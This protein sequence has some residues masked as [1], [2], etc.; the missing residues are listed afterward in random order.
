MAWSPS[1][2]GSWLTLPLTHLLAP[3]TPS[4]PSP[5]APP[6]PQAQYADLWTELSR[7]AAQCYMLCGRVRSAAQLNA[8]VADALLARGEVAGARALYELLCTTA[9]R[10]VCGGRWQEGRWCGSQ[11]AGGAGGLGEGGG[12][13]LL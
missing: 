9:L 11:G 10:C 8:D 13:G 1:H 7:A 3:P 5:S 6:P 4:R 12:G 2:L